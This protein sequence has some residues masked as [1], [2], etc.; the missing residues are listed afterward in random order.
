MPCGE[1]VSTRTIERTC[2]PH[3]ND[4]AISFQLS[5]LRQTEFFASKVCNIREDAILE[6]HIKSYQWTSILLIDL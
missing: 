3:A 2:G 1:W 4:F 6:N 5:A